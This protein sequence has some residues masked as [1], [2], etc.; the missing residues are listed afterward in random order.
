[1]PGSH[2]AW[3]LTHEY[4]GR[5]QTCDLQKLQVA[6]LAVPLFLASRAEAEPRRSVARSLRYE[7]ADGR[8]RRGA[9]P[10]AGEAQ[11]GVC[12]HGRHA[13]RGAARGCGP[14]PADGHA[15]VSPV[16]GL[17]GAANLP[18]RWWSATDGRHVGDESWLERGQ[19]MRLD[20]D[21]AV[22]GIASQPFRL[23]W[24]ARVCR[25]FSIRCPRG[26]IRSCFHGLSSAT[27]RSP[28]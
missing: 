27:S 2:P 3:Y 23:R 14:G 6:P 13:A 10:C 15:A 24:T 9:W 22:T 20:W 17:E 8:A 21:Q 16:Q 7:D 1:M 4:V 18:G 12:R 11:R 28:F 25:Y 5:D 26:S 19:V